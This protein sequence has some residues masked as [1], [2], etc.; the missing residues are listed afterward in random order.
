MK[1]INNQKKSITVLE[2]FNLLKKKREEIKD[3]LGENPKSITEKS[4]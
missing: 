4:K 1:I 3:K 2:M